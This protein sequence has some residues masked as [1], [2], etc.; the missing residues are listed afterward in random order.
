MRVGKTIVN[1]LLTPVALVFV[2]LVMALGAVS[3]VMRAVLSVPY[4]LFKGISEAC[5][6]LLRMFVDGYNKGK[7]KVIAGVER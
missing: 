6:F 5:Q 3:T 2:V 1:I 7:A 4:G